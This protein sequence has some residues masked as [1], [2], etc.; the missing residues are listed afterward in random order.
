V[1]RTVSQRGLNSSDF[2]VQLLRSPVLIVPPGPQTPPQW[3]VTV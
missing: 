2:L 1:L 3:P